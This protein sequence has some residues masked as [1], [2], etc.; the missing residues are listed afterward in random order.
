MDRTEGTDVRLIAAPMWEFGVDQGVRQF[1]ELGVALVLSTL[2]GLER[3]V[4]Q[5]SAGLRTHTLVGVGSALF[6]QVSQYGFTDVL[7]RDHV[8]LDP[9]RVAAQVV[10]GIGFIGGGLI[11]VRR[12]AV[13][14]L[15]T[16]ATVWL[17]CAVGMACGG[18]LALLATAVTAVHFLVIRGYP[19]LTHRLPALWSAERVE[20]QLSYRVGA[21]LLPRVL[22]LC[23]TAGYRVLRVRVD[24][25]PWK[26]RDRTTRVVRAE[27]EARPADTGVAEVQL[28][29]EGTGDVLRLVGE[30]TELE[31]V[32]G[33]D[34]GRDLDDSE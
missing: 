19:L 16:A 34:A 3:A 27:E 7:L 28:A 20:L 10:S 17:T 15:T 32:L 4:Q 21:G 22:E 18:G 1:A 8:G 23:T 14:G 5:K 31:G 33:A 13:H 24:R 6:M 9:S 11:F 2:I 26:G 30:I 25:A 29:L 12:D